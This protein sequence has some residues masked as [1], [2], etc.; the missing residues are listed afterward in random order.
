MARRDIDAPVTLSILDRLTDKDPKT[1]AESPPS[2]SQAMRML[3]DGLRRD[4]EWLLNTRRTPEEV[5]EE[6]PEL[7]RSLYNYGLPDIG[8]FSAK[9]PQD[10]VRLRR[11]LEAAIASFEPRLLATRVSM[12]TVAALVK[13]V[14]FQIQGLLRIDPSP[15]HVSFDTV[16]E[17][18]AGEFEVRGD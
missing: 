11:A 7:A 9:N 14:R 2:R 8:S 6:Y 15:E 18:P 12:E 17:L 13:G 10:H 16:L 1:K 4:L 5:G 3:R